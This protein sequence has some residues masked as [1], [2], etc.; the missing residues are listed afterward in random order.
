[1]FLWLPVERG[2]MGMVIWTTTYG[3]LGLAE[4]NSDKLYQRWPNY[5]VTKRN[6]IEI[7]ENKEVFAK[8]TKNWLFVSVGSARI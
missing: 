7:E 5:D 6:L 2:I 8:S 3:L 1:M 4:H